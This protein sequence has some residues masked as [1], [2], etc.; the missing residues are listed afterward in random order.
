MQCEC[1]NREATNEYCRLHERAY[2][3]I[4]RK[5]EIWKHAADLS[6]EQYLNEIVKNPFTGAWAKEVAERLLNNKE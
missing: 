4:L 6:W 2:A 1:C 3:N 5:F